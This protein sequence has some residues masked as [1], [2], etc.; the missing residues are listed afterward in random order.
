[1]RM[2]MMMKE[3]WT[4]WSTS[5]LPACNSEVL[6]LLLKVFGVTLGAGG[7]RVTVAVGES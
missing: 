2:V 1:M 4:I 6:S 7:L 3:S 5:L